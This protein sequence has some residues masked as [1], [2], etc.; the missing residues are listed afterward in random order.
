MTASA[1]ALFKKAKTAMAHAAEML[2]QVEP[3]VKADAESRD[4][5]KS[6]ETL[7]RE[8]DEITAQLDLIQPVSKKILDAYEE[9]KKQVSSSPFSPFE[10]LLIATFLL[11]IAVFEDK[12]IAGTAKLNK[13]V[14]TITKVL[15]RP[16]VCRLTVIV[17]TLGTE[18]VAPQA[19]GS[20]S[21]HQ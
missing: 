3:D 19:R 1:S 17:L 10:P 14:A 8:M 6:L 4:Q 20:R 12:V 7:N 5:T 2:D 11:Q 16:F 21:E 18:Q 9:R 13:A 15:V